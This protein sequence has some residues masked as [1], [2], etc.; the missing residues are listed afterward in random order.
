M[1]VAISTDGQH[2][3]PHFGRCHYF[4]IV[5]MEEGKV[6]SREIINNPGHA[7]AFLPQ[8]LSEKGVS[9]I[10]AGGMGGRAEG[11]FSEQGIE[12][13]VGVSG[14]IDEVLDELAK[15]TLKAGE[16]LC[17]PGSGR[18]YGVEKNKCD[19]PEHPHNH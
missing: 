8:F 16:S 15:G 3:S 6:L 13:I 9:C 19:H 2:V 5:E 7:P 10:I 18:G 12:T 1:K 4:T 11:L 14:R 17:K